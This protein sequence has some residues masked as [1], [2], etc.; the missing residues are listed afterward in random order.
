ML[1]SEGK[2]RYALFRYCLLSWMDGRQVLSTGTIVCCSHDWF[3]ETS[4]LLRI[5]QL[6]ALVA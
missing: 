3:I 6:G 5:V 2:N 4:R 1:Q